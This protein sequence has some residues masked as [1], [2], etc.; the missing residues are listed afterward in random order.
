MSRTVLRIKT[1]RIWFWHSL[2][3]PKCSQHTFSV[4]VTLPKASYGP[5]S[6]WELEQNFLPCPALWLRSVG[7]Q[8]QLGLAAPRHGYL[9]LEATG[10][11]WEIDSLEFILS[12]SVWSSVKHRR[13]ILPC[14]AGAGLYRV[15]FAKTQFWAWYLGPCPMTI[16]KFGHL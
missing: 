8:T 15:I 12:S 9:G 11:K 10:V 6:S 14:G 5:D 1:E 2:C 3:L 16:I 13:E 4:S 7:E